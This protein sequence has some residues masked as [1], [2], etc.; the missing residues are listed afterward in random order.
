ML[1]MSEN[2]TE[3]KMFF[4]LGRNWDIHRKIVIFNS[5]LSEQHPLW[6][7]FTNKKYRS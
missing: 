5:A 7:Y 3:E 6:S 4:T 2:I 1:V